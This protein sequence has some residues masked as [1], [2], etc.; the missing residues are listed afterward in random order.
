[1]SDLSAAIAEV[2]KRG[3][4]APVEVQAAAVESYL[5]NSTKYAVVRLPRATFVQRGR[6]LECSGR[7][8]PVTASRHALDTAFYEGVGLIA[9]VRRINAL[10]RA[11]TP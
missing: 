4:N 8:I 2:L 11:R 3:K 6:A 5:K 9:L 1:M 7:A 10:G